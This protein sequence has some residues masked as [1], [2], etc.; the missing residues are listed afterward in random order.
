M[1]Q[2]A[3]FTE[4]AAGRVKVVYGKAHLSS[5]FS[6]FSLSVCRS[7]EMKYRLERLRTSVFHIESGARPITDRVFVVCKRPGPKREERTGGGSGR[8]RE[9]QLDKLMIYTYYL[10]RRSTR[11]NLT[12]SR[13]GIASLPPS[14]VSF[15]GPLLEN[16]SEKIVSWA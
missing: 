14:D 11:K 8:K 9:V 2:K 6:R 12:W 4:V 13:S 7:V 10:S 16:L 15:L 3:S 5:S 1:K